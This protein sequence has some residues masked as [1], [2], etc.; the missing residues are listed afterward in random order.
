MIAN[1][2][3]SFI[4][5]GPKKGIGPVLRRSSLICLMVTALLI[6]GF[7]LPQAVSAEKKPANQHWVGTWATSP[8]SRTG[9]SFNDQTL[10][11]IV[12]TSIGG[13][14]VRVRISNAYGTQPLDIG[15]AH[16]ALR[17][18]CTLIYP[19]YLYIPGP[20]PH[21]TSPP[22]GHMPHGG[23]LR[24]RPG[25]GSGAHLRGIDIDQNMARRDC[26]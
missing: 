22:G 1:R 25:I 3:L 16:I 12:R 2:F 19:G 13:P 23:R 18:P 4:K 26:G 5:R 21:S 8:Q 10:R 11:M 20:S 15:E 24:H 9:V 17:A 7:A 6:S 14:E